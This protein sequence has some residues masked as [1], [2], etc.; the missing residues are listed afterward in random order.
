MAM[1]RKCWVRREEFGFMEGER[2]G[3]VV[4]GGVVDILFLSGGWL[5]GVF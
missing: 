4:I 2:G 1:C 3:G 5:F